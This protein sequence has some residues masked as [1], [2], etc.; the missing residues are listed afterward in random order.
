MHTIKY[1]LICIFTAKWGKERKKSLEEFTDSLTFLFL[2]R[3]QEN[4]NWIV[5]RKVRGSTTGMLRRQVLEGWPPCCRNKAS[6]H[7]YHLSAAELHCCSK[8]SVVSV[9]VFCFSCLL[10]LGHGKLY[11]ILYNYRIFIPWLGARHKTS[12]YTASATPT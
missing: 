10:E 2:F 5:C 4:A 3:H 9:S 1:T 6:L 12:A 8:I 11:K 7:Y